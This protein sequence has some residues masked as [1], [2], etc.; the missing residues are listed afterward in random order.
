MPRS[1]QQTIPFQQMF[2]D[3][4]CR[5]TDRYY[6]KCI[7]YYEIDYQLVHDAEQVAI[8]RLWGD[9]HNSVDSSVH[10]QYTLMDFYTKMKEHELDDYIKERGDEHDSLR[11]ELA[12]ILHQ[13]QQNSN[14]SMI[15]L[16][17]AT[18]GVEAENV[19][20][21]RSRLLRVENDIQG[22][23]RRLGSKSEVLDGKKRMELMYMMLHLDDLGRYE[24]RSDDLIPSGLSA[25]DLIAP[26]SFNFMRRDMFSMGDKLCSI[27]AIQ[28]D[29][30]KMK[31]YMLADLLDMETCQ[32][33]TIHA[34]S[35]DQAEAIK[36]LRRKVSDVGRMKIDEQIKAAHSG[37]DIDILPTNLNKFG[38]GGEA[39]LKYVE[40]ED[41]RMFLVTVLIMHTG[42]TR[43]EV[44]NN[45]FQAQ[46]LLQPHGA[47]LLRLDFQQEQALVSTLPLGLN[48]IT[49]NR[50]MTTRNIA[51][52]IPFTTRDLYQTSPNALYYGLNAVSKT[53][54]M[55]DRTSLPNAN[56]I[57]LGSPGS[58]KSVVG[59]HEIYFVILLTDNDVMICDPEG[60]YMAL[61]AA[62]HGQTIRIAPNSHSYINPM[63][64]DIYHADDISPIQMKTSFII[65]MIELMVG[66]RGSL[67]GKEISCIDTAVQ[68]VYAPYLANPVPEN[69]PILGD[70]QQAL[71]EQE[72]PE[73]HD[74]ALSMEMYVNG[75]LNVFNHRSNV[76]Y[77]NRLVCYDVKDLG[78][79]LKPLGMLIVQ[80]QVWTRVAKNREQGKYTRYY[81]DEF[82]VLLREP[83][84]AAYCSAMWKRFRKWGG[85]PTAI[86]QNVK[87]LLAS[88]EIENILENS[89][90]MVLLN[91]APGDRAILEEK[92]NISKTQSAHITHA[93]PGSG[94]MIFG[95]IVLPFSNKIPTDTEMYRIM[96]TKLTEVAHPKGGVS[97]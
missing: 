39:M 49:V 61:V 5:V 8:Y 52:L 74:L 44:E 40:D 66:K 2:D 6:S 81:M 65:S 47:K 17:Y 57:I 59:K 11:M 33:I 70:L 69:M 16:K 50:S 89:S 42:N 23:L 86:T 37:Y 9:L 32:I 22:R 54:I 10:A 36:I 56:G 97:V 77:H 43:K 18:F 34:K 68:R 7:Q 87:D 19:R 25:R 78:D 88:P 28:I 13:H 4:I 21:A 67:D 58:G 48:Q 30:G 80:D 63:D 12:K 93:D 15:K 31:D 3:G 45:I 79:T 27:S 1:A 55:A 73:A 90:F 29:A 51:M 82:H 76:D 75:S 92:F 84:T 85:V 64:I 20:M 60:E 95:D 72:A 24:F 91:Q 38:Q 53:M 83:Q 35:F 94:L 62:L 46:T 14:T 71:I 96:T 41:E 26:S